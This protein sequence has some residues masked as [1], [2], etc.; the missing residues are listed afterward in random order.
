MRELVEALASASTGQMH[1][2]AASRTRTVAVPGATVL[3]LPQLDMDAAVALL[4]ATCRPVELGD[5]EARQVTAACGSNALELRLVGGILATG[6][7]RADEII[8]IGRAARSLEGEPTGDDFAAPVDRLQA[9]WRA[10]LGSVFAEEAQLQMAASLAVFAGSFSE[11]AARSVSR[12][13]LEVG[14]EGAGWPAEDSRQALL[15]S[16]KATLQ[17]AKVQLRSLCHLG[18]LEDR[19]LADGE[20]AWGISAKAWVACGLTPAPIWAWMAMP[21]DIVRVCTPLRLGPMQP[22]MQ[23]WPAAT[24]CTTCTARRPPSCRRQPVAAS[25]YGSAA[26]RP[27]WSA[28]WIWGSGCTESKSSWKAAGWSLKSRP[29][30]WRRRLRCLP[31]V[32]RRLPVGMSDYCPE[33]LR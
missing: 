24:R 31:Q 27:S 8:A 4:R 9:W 32:R 18:I 19:S 6:L 13:A 11:E 5:A 22:S 12:S 15:G 33:L 3:E 14:A 16:S 25:S 23:A 7:R 1:L 21:D 20:R 29:D 10:M 2:V 28:R 26:R 30:C 17:P